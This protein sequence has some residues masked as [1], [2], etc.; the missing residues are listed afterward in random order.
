MAAET[1][2]DALRLAERLL[3]LLDQGSFAATYKYAVLLA[4]LDLCLEHTGT[5]GDPPDQLT[6]RQI[7]EKVT[8]LYW[9][10]ARSYQGRAPLRQGGGEG[11]QIGIL[12]DIL[13]LQQS[14]AEH[15]R[16]S[17]S[18][19][20]ARLRA[21]EAWEALVW[22]VEW[23]LIEMPLPRLQVVG[24]EE[25]RF[26]YD[27]S[28]GLERRRGGSKVTVSRAEVRRYQRGEAGG[29]DNNLRLRPGV[30][31]AL[32]ALNGVLRPLLHRLWAQ[33]VARLNRLEED[34]LQQHLFGAE[35]VDL[36][37]VRGDLRGLQGDRCFYCEETLRGAADVDHFVPWAR[38]PDNAIDNLV[39]AHPACNR[40]KRD[41]L[42]GVDHLERWRRRAGASAAELAR[43]ANRHDWEHAPERVWRV[44]QA[45]YRPLPEGALLWEAGEIF[46]RLHRPRLHH[47]LG[48][49]PPSPG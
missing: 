30:G 4:M 49:D 46:S 29:F 22:E 21:P 14:L 42:A 2:A 44:S 45:L 43:I 26:L 5:R 10:Q 34:T 13:R 28:W 27:L 15:E 16:A 8:A 12:S 17:L 32:V 48:L 31:A 33:Q 20:R 25:D 24:G 35:R 11:G 19:A 18:A 9:P 7:A 40:A 37:P 41:F 6:T 3:L 1:S 23:K 36:S 39:A 38:H 47:V